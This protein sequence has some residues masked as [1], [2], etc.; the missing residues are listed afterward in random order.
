MH[1]NFLR[2]RNNEYMYVR[3]LQ[4]Y[5]ITGTVIYP[6]CTFKNQNNKYETLVFCH[7]RNETTS[8]YLRHNDIYQV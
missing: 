8:V 6:W 2:F 5:I 1:F 3:L 4:L 7:E